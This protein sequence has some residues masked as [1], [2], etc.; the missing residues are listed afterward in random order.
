MKVLVV[1][2][3]CKR[4]S[5]TNIDE[6]QTL[7]ILQIIFTIGSQFTVLCYILDNLHKHSFFLTLGLS[8]TKVSPV[9]FYKTVN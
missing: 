2:E 6:Q 1:V 3:E 4:M 9:L 5:S 8:G 7:K